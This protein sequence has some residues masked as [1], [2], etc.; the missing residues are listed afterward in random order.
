M[1]VLEHQMTS[2][3]INLSAATNLKAQRAFYGY[4][5]TKM[6]LETALWESETADSESEIAIHLES[7]TAVSTSKTTVAESEMT[8]SDSETLFRNPF[9]YFFIF[10]TRQRRAEPL[11]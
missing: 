1:A 2:I 3:I 6:E 11:V 4:E 8:V 9:S 7:G 5:G 10:R